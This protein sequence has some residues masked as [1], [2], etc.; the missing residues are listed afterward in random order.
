MLVFLSN[1][2][3]LSTLTGT[4]LL[5]L[6][7]TL[8]AVSTNILAAVLIRQEDL[9]NL[10]FRL[11]SKTSP[12]TPFVIRKRLADF[13]HFG[14]VH[15][16]CAASAI[17]W[18]IAYVVLSTQIFLNGKDL[19]AVEYIDMA[20]CYLFIILL[21]VICVPATPFLRFKHHNTFETAHR[22]GGW[23]AIAT[24]WI[25]T[26]TTSSSSSSGPPL[27]QHPSLYLLSAITSLLILPWLRIRPVSV[28]FTR[29]SSRELSLTF[30]YDSMPFCSTMRFSM[31]PLFEWHAFATIP[32]HSSLLAK[33]TKASI[34]VAESGDWT[35]RLLAN[36]PSRI[37]LRDPPTR[38]FLHMARMFK[39]I[40]VVATG[41][42]IGPVL[43]FL[44]SVPAAVPAAAPADMSPGSRRVRVLWCTRGP[45]PDIRRKILAVDPDAVILDSSQGRF[46]LK[47]MAGEIVRRE[48]LE[49][50]FVVSNKNITDDIVRGLGRR[51]VAGYGA[52]FDS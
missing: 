39:G 13:H 35:R 3:V 32:L 40:L 22:F 49:A 28:T 44:A 52:S 51:G 12:S 45:H 33:T 2:I 10:L 37:W 38:N 48:R 11:I 50:V 18:Y 6:F 7:H 24:F 16:G 15:T 9:L 21:L 4:R 23:A 20:T 27:W 25:H 42:G 19:R 43:S 46:D 36:P 1:S 47:G 14:G 29:L 26:F 31:S 8:N 34:L 17:L 30:D 5:N 41:A